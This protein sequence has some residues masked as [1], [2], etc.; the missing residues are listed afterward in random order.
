M[1]QE[2]SLAKRKFKEALMLTR[3]LNNSLDK[4]HAFETIGDSIVLLYEESLSLG[5][6]G[7]DEIECHARLGG[8]FFLKG[9]CFE[10]VDRVFDKGLGSTPCYHRCITEIEKAL[11]LDTQRGGVFFRYAKDRDVLLG[12]LALLSGANSYFIK[13]ADVI[14]GRLSAISYLEHEVRLMHYLGG[15][16][17]PI[18][19]FELGSLYADIAKESVRDESVHRQKAI[20]WFIR[21][22]N[23]AVASDAYSPFDIKRRA[24]EELEKVLV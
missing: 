3:V 11:Q 8:V 12:P 15:S 6:T 18:L 10:V 2:E 21:A 23:E 9:N 22:A 16:H 17:F 5:L 19:F 14:N 4:E 24:Q 13:Q 1:S 20:M 7:K